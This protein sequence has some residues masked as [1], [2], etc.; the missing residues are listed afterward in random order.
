ML[1][2]FAELADARVPEQLELDG[3]SL[4]GALKGGALAHS[5]KPLYWDYG[6]CRGKAYTQAVRL[7]DWKG[8]RSSRTGV[9]E[10]YDLSRDIGEVSDIASTHP[11]IVERIRDIMDRAVTPSPRYRIG[12]IYRG[13]PIWKRSK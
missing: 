11:E 1:P 6:H 2:T 9:T 4:L 7:D 10:L 12:T 5:R 13:S 8:I 3:A